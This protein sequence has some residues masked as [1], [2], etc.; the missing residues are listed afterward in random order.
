MFAWILNTKAEKFS[1]AGSIIPAEDSRGAG[2]GARRR[3]SSKK[4]CTPKFVIAEPKKRG[5]NSPQA[6]R[7]R[8]KG[9]PASS[10][11]ATSSKSA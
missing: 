6:M 7:S 1:A 10:S 11:S 4:F 3:Y 2:G 5:V 8:S 9:S